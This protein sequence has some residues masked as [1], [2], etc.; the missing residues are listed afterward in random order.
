MGKTVADLTLDDEHMTV[1]V[2]DTLQEAAKRLLT[3]SGG[4]VVVLDDDQRVKGVLGQRQ[5][6]KALS[7][8][9]DAASAQCHEHMEMDFMQVELKDSIKG[10]LADIKTRSPQ[11]V[12]AVDENQEFVGYFSPGDYQEAVQLVANL[13]GL[14]L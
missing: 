3:I 11:A 8:G 5:L 4:I 9:V 2:S 1:G 14:T 7:E 12:V 13:K 10:V 6:I